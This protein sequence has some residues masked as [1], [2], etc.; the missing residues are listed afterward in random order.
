MNIAVT[1]ATG[2]IGRYVVRQLAQAGHDC[3]CWYRPESDRQGLEDLNEHLVW[4][5][6]DLGDLEACREL[7]DG[8]QAV[9][10]AALFHPGGG[11]RG[12]EGELLPFVERNVLGTLALIEAARKAGVSRFVLVSTCAVYEKILDDR[13]LDEAHPTWPASHYGAH[14]AALE[15]FVYSYGLGMGYPICACP[16]PVFTA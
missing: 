6:G 3:R 8:C 16:Q 9:V 1:G 7:V 11:F 4:L 2:F 14:K 12:S 5:P 13:P 10:H 15:Q